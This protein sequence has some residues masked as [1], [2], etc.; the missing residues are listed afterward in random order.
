MAK[1]LTAK[2]YFDHN[3]GCTEYQVSTVWPDMNS[4]SSYMAEYTEEYL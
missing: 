2:G 3:Y 4:C 1:Q